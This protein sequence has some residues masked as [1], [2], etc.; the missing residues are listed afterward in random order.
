MTKEQT[1]PELWPGV[2]WEKCKRKGYQWVCEVADL[3]CRV[4]PGHD[5]LWCG[6][7]CR[8]GCHWQSF[9]TPAQ[10]EALT[11]LRTRILDHLTTGAQQVGANAFL[12]ALPE[13]FRR[14]LIV[15]LGGTL[16]CR[17]GSDWYVVE[18]PGEPVRLPEES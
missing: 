18:L 11:W 16:H 9:Y 17:N 13:D 8:P 5:G 6:A 2:P 12:E 14:E 7:F 4:W 10:E 3:E 15:G 1:P